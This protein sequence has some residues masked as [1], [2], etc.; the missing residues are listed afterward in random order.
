[1]R[2]KHKKKESRPPSFDILRFQKKDLC[3]RI[4]REWLK[5]KSCNKKKGNLFSAVYLLQYQIYQSF[6]YCSTLLLKILFL[7]FF[8]LV[9]LTLK[10]SSALYRF[11]WQ[12]SNQFVFYSYSSCNVWIKKKSSLFERKE[13]KFCISFS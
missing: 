13:M 6:N 2:I 12:S 4:M 5:K 8:T 3:M 1:M 10:S 11:F 9:F 7:V